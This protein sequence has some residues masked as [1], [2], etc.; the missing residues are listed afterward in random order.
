MLVT[1]SLKIKN[2]AANFIKKEPVALDGTEIIKVDIE[3]TLTV[4]MITS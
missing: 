3:N 4:T 1:L 2:S